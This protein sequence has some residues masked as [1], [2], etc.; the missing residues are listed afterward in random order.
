V[1]L[2]IIKILASVGGSKYF[3]L[4]TRYSW[5]VESNDAPFIPIKKYEQ[6]KLITIDFN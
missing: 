5:R 4:G 3:A 2:S 6:I 1:L